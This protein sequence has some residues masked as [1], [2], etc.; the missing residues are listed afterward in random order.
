M[1]PE[2]I[3]LRLYGSLHRFVNPG[4]ALVLAFL[5]FYPSEGVRKLLSSR[6]FDGTVLD[7]YSSAKTAFLESSF[8]YFLASLVVSFV[9]LPYLNRLVSSSLAKF[10][11]NFT[12]V[13]EDRVEE[14]VRAFKESDDIKAIQERS[15]N[16]YQKIKNIF[17]C[18][19]ALCGVSL[20]FLLIYIF[21][22][23]AI[24]F[25]IS[26]IF[27]VVYLVFSYFY[28]KKIMILYITS[29]VYYQKVS[30]KLERIQSEGS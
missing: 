21:H 7:F 14:A 13:L 29:I 22:D 4:R 10:E 5:I 3:I 12:G 15:V 18:M 8:L 26:L 30:R 1:I 6:F 24:S 20:S 16:A 23:G 28:V 17:M 19:E 27:T 9:L 11:K 25:L 2:A